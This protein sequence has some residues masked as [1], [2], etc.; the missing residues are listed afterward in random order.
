[1]TEAL[2]KV[3]NN[4]DRIQRVYELLRS[5]GADEQQAHVGSIALAEKFTWTGAVL[6]FNATGKI[7]TDDPAC[8]EYVAKDYA[9]LL[10][11]EAPDAGKPKVD[12]VLLALARAGNQ[13]AR[14]KIYKQ[15][16]DLAATDALIADKPAAESAAT[17]DDASKKKNGATDHRNNPFHK[18]NWNIS[19]QGALLRAV[20]PTKSAQIADSVGSKIGATQPNLNY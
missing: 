9:F 1:M 16:G 11:A 3:L 5:Y 6:N 8:K 13:T 12:P 20:G 2:D 17:D 10:P 7:A 15:L 14:T 4:A 18:S 19:K